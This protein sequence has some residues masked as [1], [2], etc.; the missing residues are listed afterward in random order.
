MAF[1]RRQ[2][3]KKGVCGVAAAEKNVDFPRVPSPPF[4]LFLRI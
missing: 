1:G 2:G 3:L 4:D